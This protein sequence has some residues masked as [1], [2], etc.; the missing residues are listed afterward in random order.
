MSHELAHQRYES[1]T[2]AG[3]TLVGEYNPISHHFECHVLDK[4]YGRKILLS[5]DVME[6]ITA[7]LKAEAV[8]EKAAA[9]DDDWHQTIRTL[10]L[11]QAEYLKRLAGAAAD[12]IVDRT[13]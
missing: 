13:H 2:P 5:D 4:A 8:A 7:A 6:G 12:I 1:L 9:D 11:K 10:K 3:H